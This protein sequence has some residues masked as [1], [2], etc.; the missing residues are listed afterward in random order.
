[1]RYILHPGT[2]KSKT[3]GQE[4]YISAARLARLYGLNLV[5]CIVHTEPKSYAFN[6]YDIHLHPRYDG[7]Y[8]LPLFSG[9]PK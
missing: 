2:V 3:D 8:T 9:K 5:D 7:D 1:M 4:H 6:V